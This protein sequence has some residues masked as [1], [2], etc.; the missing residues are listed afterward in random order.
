M[1]ASHA[2]TLVLL[3]GWAGA[4][5]LAVPPPPIVN[6]EQTSDWPAVGMLAVV[7]QSSGA[8]AV[9]CS[10]TLI[11][12]LAV[13]TAAH[14]EEAATAYAS[15]GHR[16]VFVV[17]PAL[18]E[19]QDYVE[20][21]DWS[22]HPDYRFDGTG[23]A[24]DVA[25]GLLAEPLAS[26]VT[27]MPMHTEDLGTAWY[28]QELTLVG[29]GVTADGGSDAGVKRTTSLPVFTLDSDFVYAV[30]PEPDGSNACSGDSGGA[31]LRPGD[32]GDELVGV[33]SFVFS[34]HDAAYACIGGGVGATRVDVFGAWM[35]DEAGI[36]SD[37]GADVDGEGGSGEVDGSGSG[38]SGGSNPFL[39]ERG[40]GG[41]SA[42]GGAAGLLG[43]VAM[44]APL[45][46]RRR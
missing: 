38:G 37:G 41:C 5:A 29:F 43:W 21:Q 33:L 1:P 11:D 27:P 9:F 35:S 19:A 45:A 7:E 23:V 16:I 44:L 28:D 15:G 30:D 14:C 32:Q 36:A 34:Y 46:R 8:A 40:G 4:P 12:D 31:A 18:A 13:A 26:G 22:V 39:E 2:G 24:A 42:L 3:L 20:V 17:G 10:A 6:G 25:V